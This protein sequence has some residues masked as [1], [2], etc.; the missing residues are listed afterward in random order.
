MADT[1]L[2]NALELFAY[3]TR[4]NG[5]ELVWTALFGGFNL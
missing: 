1:Q 3:A 5:F 2:L 4:Y